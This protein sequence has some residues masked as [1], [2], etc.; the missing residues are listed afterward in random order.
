MVKLG[1]VDL[2]DNGLNAQLIPI[3]QFNTHPSYQKSEKY[4]DIALIRLQTQIQF[5]EFVRPACLNT[6]PLQS[7]QWKKAIASGFGKTQYGLSI[8]YKLILL[9]LYS[10]T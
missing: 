6:E 3:A 10:Y 7:L 5:N 4:N 2:K 1:V 9:Q 8:T